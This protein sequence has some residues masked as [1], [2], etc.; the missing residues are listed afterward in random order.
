LETALEQQRNGESSTYETHVAAADGAQLFVLNT[1]VPLWRDNRIVGAIAVATDLTERK[2]TELALAQARDQALEASR[3]KSEF[4]ATMSHEIRTPMNGIIGM[5][6]L[7]HDTPLDQEQGEYVTVVGNSA[8]ELLRIINDILDFSKLEADRL[9]LESADF[10]PVTVVEAAA[11]LLA[12]NAREKGLTLLTYIDPAIPPWLR[13]DAGRLRQIL[14][15][16]LGNAVKFTEHGEVVVQARLEEAAENDIT[17]RFAVSDSGIG[18]SDDA[19]KRLFQPFVQADG[20][21][22]RKYGGT[23]LGLAICKRLV[24]G[25]GGTISVN[26]TEGQGSTFWFTARFMYS[27]VAP[28][29]VQTP[30]FQGMRALVIDPSETSRE[31]VQRV[32]QSWGMESDLIATGREGLRRLS[33]AV[34]NTYNVVFTDMALPD[35]SGLEF[36][37]SAL[38]QVSDVPVIMLTAS[39]RRGQGET[40]VASG[41][42]AYLTKPFKRAQLAAAIS[43]ALAGPEL[44]S[45]REPE[46]QPEESPFYGTVPQEREAAPTDRVHTPFGGT[47]APRPS[48]DEPIRLQ[49]RPAPAQPPTLEPAQPLYVPRPTVTPPMHPA[50]DAPVR[51][52]LILL[53]EDNTNNQIMAMRQLEKLGQNVHIVSNG[54]QAVKALTMPNKYEIVFMDCQMP[55]MDG[56]DATR[57]IRKVEVSSGK[58]V[59]IV[60][61]TANAMQGDRETCIAA[62]MDDYIAK[63]VTRE[64]LRAAL[65]RYLPA[66]DKANN[67]S[68]A[69]AGQ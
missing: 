56:F 7:L 32:L 17:L 29:S 3:L 2:R 55:E 27:T 25:M 18:L 45:A 20:S 9:V 4:L 58:H 47:P 1:N 21:H 53:V 38:Q 14:L 44:E 57:E 22:S 63:P 13:G 5:V 65:T 8:Q 37:R 19:R 6:E 16:L 48:E 33:Y 23:G 31:V 59:P 43:S 24:D 67:S 61:M 66:P 12:A 28:E 26:S 40:A 30:D 49:P 50:A 52:G 34:D 10:E 36:G 11:E 39:D 60:A 42:A 64:L 15:N 51:K 41:F 69:V 62:G 35:M 46:A 68:V 54:V